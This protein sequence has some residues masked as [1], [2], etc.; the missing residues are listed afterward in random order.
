MADYFDAGKFGAIVPFTFTI[1]NATTN[2]SNTDLSYT[3]DTTSVVMPVDGSVVGIS[4]GSS[5]NVTAGS[6]AFRAHK[7]STEYADSGYPVATLDATNSNASYG[8]IRPGVLKFTAGQKVGVSVTTATDMSPTNT[9][10]FAAVL[11]V[12]LNAV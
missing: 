11:W 4:V 12:Q 7:A 8:T 5:A 2:A 3:A 6:A 10:D 1:Q 9:N